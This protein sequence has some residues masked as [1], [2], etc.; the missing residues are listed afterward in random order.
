MSSTTFPRARKARTASAK[1]GIEI[2][3]YERPAVEPNAGMK[4]CVADN[5]E[6]SNNSH[7]NAAPGIKGVVNPTFARDGGEKATPERPAMNIKM[8]EDHFDARWLTRKR[9]N[10]SDRNQP[11]LFTDNALDQF[12]IWHDQTG[13]MHWLDLTAGTGGEGTLTLAQHVLAVDANEAAYRMA[14]LALA[15]RY[16]N[17]GIGFFALPQAA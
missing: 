1:A 12:S 17:N 7:I 9:S 8:V 5:G 4:G 3:F 15:R 11:H 2:V 6:T 10:I 13:Q 16:S 14:A